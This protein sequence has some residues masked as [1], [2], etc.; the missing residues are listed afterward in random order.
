MGKKTKM[1]DKIE[2]KC[3]KKTEKVAFAFGFM[4]AQGEKYADYIPEDADAAMENAFDTCKEA[5]SCRIN[6]KIGRMECE[7]GFRVVKKSFKAKPN[8]PFDTHGNTIDS[9]V[10]CYRK[11][12]VK[13]RDSPC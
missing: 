6:N 5:S 12:L 4:E 7:A 2:T 8:E 10:D 3:S 1:N 13:A 11:L 9:V